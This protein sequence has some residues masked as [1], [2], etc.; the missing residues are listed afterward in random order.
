MPRKPRVA[1]SAQPNVGSAAAV[2]GGFRSGQDA[3]TGLQ[4]RSMAR[5]ESTRR[6]SASSRR[7][8]HRRVPAAVLGEPGAIPWRE[9]EGSINSYSRRISRAAAHRHEWAL[10]PLRVRGIERVRLH[11]DLTILAKLACALA[12]ARPSPPRLGRAEGARLHRQNDPRGQNPRPRS[13]HPEAP[14]LARS[15]RATADTGAS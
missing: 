3:N 14:P 9:L 7:P 6:S 15:I 12:R 13:P 2:T 11:A 1:S 4:T 5:P 10:L 8:A